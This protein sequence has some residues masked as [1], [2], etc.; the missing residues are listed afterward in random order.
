ME[1]LGEEIKISLRALVLF[2]RVSG[3]NRENLR[4]EAVKFFVCVMLY[5]LR[6]QKYRTWGVGLMQNLSIV[7]E[8]TILRIRSTTEA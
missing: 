2:T 6:L 5:R 4:L 7:Y 1:Q 3:M 8:T